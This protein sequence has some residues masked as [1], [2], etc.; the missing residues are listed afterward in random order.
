MAAQVVAKFRIHPASIFFINPVDCY[1]ADNLSAIQKNNNYVMASNTSLLLYCCFALSGASYFPF[2]RKNKSEPK[3]LRFLDFVGW[4]SLVLFGTAICLI[5]VT[6]GLHAL[7]IVCILSTYDRGVF[8]RFSLT[9][10]LLSFVG[11]LTVGFVSQRFQAFIIGQL[12]SLSHFQAWIYVCLFS[13]LF[14]SDCDQNAQS[15]PI[16]LRGKSR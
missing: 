6:T 12:W 9:L 10:Y 5:K 14:D 16:W 15:Q 1:C 8:H 3:A 2:L 4:V 13:A 11:L 7:I